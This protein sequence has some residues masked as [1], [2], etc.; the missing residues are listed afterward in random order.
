MRWIAGLLLA[1]M[2]VAA[3]AEDAR[4]SEL[5][6]VLVPMRKIPA[7]HLRLRG[8]TPALTTIK[9]KLRDWMETHLSAL[10]PNGDA[11]AL[12]R[13]LNDELK[14]GEFFCAYVPKGGETQCPD[15]SLLGF[16][17]QFA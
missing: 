12:A 8:A 3:W 15:W 5:Q 11:E 16:G 4:L 10:E 14:R 13:Q 9:H 1:A 17:N 2:P 7:A 6:G